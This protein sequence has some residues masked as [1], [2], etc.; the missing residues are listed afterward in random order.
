MVS[1]TV[2]VTIP[3]ATTVVSGTVT[4]DA[5]FSGDTFNLATLTVDGKQVGGPDTAQPISFT[6]DTTVFP[7]GPHTIGISVKYALPSGKFRWAQGAVQ[8]TVDNT[9]PVAPVLWGARMDGDVYGTGD[10]P[11]DQAT[12]NTFEQHAGKPVDICHFGQPNPWKQSFAAGPFDLCRARNALPLCS[13]ATDTESLSAIASG[14]RDAEWT[15]WA[16][17]AGQWANR[18]LLRLNW[19]MNGHWYSWGQQP[20]ADYVSSWRRIHDL[21]KAHA[22]NVD[23]VWCPNVVFSNSTPLSLLFPGDQYVDM[24]GVDGYNFGTNPLKPNVWQSFD[25]VMSTTFAQLAQLS[26]TKRIWVCETASTEIG[27]DKAAWITDMWQRLHSGAYPQVEAL[28]W[29]NWNIVEGSGRADWP[30]ESSLAAQTA[31]Q[32]GLAAI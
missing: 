4:V 25:S 3:G 9:V 14:S 16:T 21:I 7:N 5:D 12:W 24:L 8:V 30:I 31:F 32:T 1:N 17:A 15:A 27:G 18:I 19:E 23:L 26:P 28:V 6:L 13:M 11:W 20:S 22:P 2:S 29:F 10:A